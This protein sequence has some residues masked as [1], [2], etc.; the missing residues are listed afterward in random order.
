M[1]LL[2]V[3]LEKCFLKSKMRKRLFNFTFVL[4]MEYI[5][6]KHSNLGFR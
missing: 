3:L 5:A 4:L 1:G 6:Y 2:T